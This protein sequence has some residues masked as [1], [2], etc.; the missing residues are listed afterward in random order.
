MAWWDYLELA[1]AVLFGVFGLILTF[2]ARDVDRWPRRLCIAIFSTAA[3]SAALDL[4]TSTA[5]QLPSPLPQ[6]L[7]L[8]DA[9]VTPIPSLLVFA[10]FLHCCGEDY[11]R[12]KVMGVLWALGAAM[13]AAGIAAQLSGEINAAPEGTVRFG[14][15]LVLSLQF[16]H[17]HISSLPQKSLL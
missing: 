7:S 17:I 14:F 10:Y 15:W 1:A 9:L 8:V 2:I 12:S 16:M 5:V 6:G 13:V 3:A 4:L 11:R